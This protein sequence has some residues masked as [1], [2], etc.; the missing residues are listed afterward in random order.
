MSKNKKM[1]CVAMPPITREEYFRMIRGDDT[2]KACEA[3]IRLA[4]NYSDA[5]F[6][7][8]QCER[9]LFNST[10][11]RVIRCAAMG[12]GHVARL[13]GRC[14]YGILDKI[15][16][17][18]VGN[19]KSVLEDEADNIEFQ[20]EKWEEKREHSKKGKY[21][22][23]YPRPAVTVDIVIL[24]V[25]NGQ[26]QVLLIKRGGEPFKN[27]WA[28]PGGFVDENESLEAAARRELAE[29]TGLTDVFIEQLYSFGDP[30]RDPRGRV[31][32]VAYYALVSGDNKISAGSDASSVAWIDARFILGY[33]GSPPLFKLAFDHKDILECAV[34][35]LRNKLEYTTVGFQLLPKRFT[36]RQLQVVYE[37]ILE[38]KLDVGNFRKKILQLGVVKETKKRIGGAHRPAR[39]FEFKKGA[40]I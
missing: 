17:L 16:E 19:L 4:M 29:E 7:L 21:S 3:I 26:L 20:L 9:F 39:L 22:Y 28:I 37:A 11:E 34:S 35:R 33:K 8:G 36:L 10:D 12:A 14:G 27:C 5:D 1:K 25:R 18:S 15:R 30:G 38:K 13:H 32:T 40:A 31:I 24:T 23:E 2:D 6:I